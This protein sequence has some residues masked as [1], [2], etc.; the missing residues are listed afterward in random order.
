M[1]QRLLICIHSSMS[2]RSG[3][4][5]VGTSGTTRE[6]MTFL[7]PCL[8]V[9]PSTESAGGRGVNKEREVNRRREVCECGG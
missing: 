3:S 1:T 8:S 2:L 5:R 7:L 6:V 9:V 4:H